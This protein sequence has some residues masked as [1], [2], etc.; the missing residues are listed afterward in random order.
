MARIRNKGVYMRVDA[1]LFEVHNKF[2]KILKDNG[3]R[4]STQKA[5]ALMARNIK[6]PNKIDLINDGKKKVRKKRRS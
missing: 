3:I 4:P 2:R 5:T 1:A 6:V